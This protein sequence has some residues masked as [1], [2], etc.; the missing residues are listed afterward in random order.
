ML[1]EV[2]QSLGLAGRV[3][4]I[5][6]RKNVTAVYN[7]LDVVCSASDS[8]G[9]PN[10]LCEAMSCGLPCVA[11]NVGDSAW[12][13]DDSRF[14]APPGDPARLA[15]CIA[16]ALTTIT[17]DDAVARRALRNRIR[18]NFSVENLTDATEAAIA[19]LVQGGG[20]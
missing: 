5:G 7:A 9:F 2:S 17:P 6:A 8:E 14:I 20:R 15:E 13:V 19:A 18:S 12:I 1:Q 11:T 10:V 3:S 16:S 4:W